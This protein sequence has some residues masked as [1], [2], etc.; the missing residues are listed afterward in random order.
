MPLPNFLISCLGAYLLLLRLLHFSD[1]KN[2]REGD[3][4]YKIKPII[5]HLRTKFSQMFS[6]FQDLCIDES[7]TLFKGRL[8]F[9]QYIPSKRHRFGIKTF[10]ICDCETGYV[11]DFIVYTGATT[12]IVP[13]MLL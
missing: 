7:L 12:E 2:P 6:P 1:N 10:V 13:G 11:L 8:L 5:D 3:R 4:L 9:K